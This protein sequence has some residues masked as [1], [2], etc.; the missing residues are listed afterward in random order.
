MELN[1][2]EYQELTKYDMGCRFSRTS[3]DGKLELVPD[4]AIAVAGTVNRP[5]ESSCKQLSHSGAVKIGTAEQLKSSSFITVANENSVGEAS[6]A[7]FFT[8]NAR[9]LV[10][11]NT[12]ARSSF[13][14]RVAP[15]PK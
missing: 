13:L 15:K 9:P 4:S 3:S 10:R 5:S 11:R 1:Y 7:S 8:K 2:S 6:A 14:D 12:P